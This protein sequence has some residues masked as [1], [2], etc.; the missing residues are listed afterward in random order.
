MDASTAAEQQHNRNLALLFTSERALDGKGCRT[1][2]CAGVLKSACRSRVSTLNCTTH[3]T[4]RARRV[5]EQANV[6]AAAA[7][8]GRA[9]GGC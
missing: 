1:Y 4:Q 9:R 3:H 7:G 2:T 5:G 8:A 6:R